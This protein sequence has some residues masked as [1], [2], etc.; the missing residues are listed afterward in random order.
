MAD[1]YS[2][3]ARLIGVALDVKYRLAIGSHLVLM[4]V[5]LSRRS[6]AK[7]SSAR[8]AETLVCNYLFKRW[9][10]AFVS[11]LVSFLLE[12]IL[13]PYASIMY[14]NQTTANQITPSIAFRLP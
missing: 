11:A 6:Y 10:F 2:L 3:S 12:H 1:I 14:E 5:K 4:A 13:Q 7:Q 9:D 8:S